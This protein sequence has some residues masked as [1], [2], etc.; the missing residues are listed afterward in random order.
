MEVAF[1]I[2]A[3]IAAFYLAVNLGFDLVLRRDPID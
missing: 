1:L 2:V 3:G